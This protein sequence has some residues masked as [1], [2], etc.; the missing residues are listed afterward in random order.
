[1]MRTMQ[2][3]QRPPDDAADGPAALAAGAW[4]TAAAAFE[5]QLADEPT[6]DA[7][8]GLGRARW[9]LGDAS[10]AI[11]A[12]EHAYAEHRRADDVP[13]A[14]QVA[15]LLAR[16]FADAVGNDAAAN[17]W[18]ARAERLVRDGQPSSAEGWLLLAK[19]E[20]VPNPTD[21]LPMVEQAAAVAA[22][23]KDPDLELFAL[24]KVALAEIR[25]GDVD[26]GMRHLDE[27]MAAAASPE[28]RDLR[29]LGDLYCSAVEAGEL[30]LDM[31][32]FDAWT[33][34]VMGFLAHHQ[35]PRLFTFCGTCCAEVAGAAGDWAEVERWLVDTLRTLETTGQ[36]PRC[37]HPAARLAGLR[38]QQGRLE[39]AEHLLE[40]YEDLPE[41][42][43]PMVALHLARDQHALAAARLHRRLNQIGRDTLLAVPLLVQLADVQ[44]ERGDLIGAAE[45]ARTLAGVAERSGL[46]RCEPRRTSLRGNVRAAASEP[47][48]TEPLERAL[49]AF[50]QLQMP[51]AAARARIALAR[52]VAAPDPERA[53]EEAKAALSTFERVG[54]TRDAD[55][56]A[57]FLRAL[58][59]RGRTGPKGSIDQLSKREV[60][61]LRLLG[62]GLTNAEIAARLYISTK[63]AAT[64]VGNIL[65]KLGLRNRA[66]AA[67]YA[68][69]YLPAESAAG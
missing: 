26:R 11:D 57:R 5:A 46:E 21:A 20:H 8:E 30:V 28:P 1:M 36:R 49:D 33:Q 58:G 55:G 51:H 32:R 2:D 38:V 39:E 6:P 43:Q 9:W 53:V 62:E 47:A 42:V 44:I 18:L 34:L 35:H 3:E 66:E 22:R 7:Y 41:A 23:Y 68:V 12:W 64:H 40:G 52:A 60:E 54:A 13:A 31:S 59:V 65:S 16:E 14:A 48:T 27:A 37:V 25:L 15:L 63:T 4:T 50:V 61:V 69:R 24:G 67:A 45:T 29:T 19:A 17:G 56:A 10:G